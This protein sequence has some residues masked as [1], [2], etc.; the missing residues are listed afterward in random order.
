VHSH[1]HRSCGCKLG[2]NCPTD[3]PTDKY[4]AICWNNLRNKPVRSV[5]FKS[6]DSS[7]TPP[8]HVLPCLLNRQK[9]VRLAVCAGYSPSAAVY[10]GAFSRNVNISVIGSQP[11][12]TLSGPDFHCEQLPPNPEAHASCS[13]PH[14]TPRPPPPPPHLTSEVA[15]GSASSVVIESSTSRDYHGNPVPAEGTEGRS[16]SLDITTADELPACAALP[17]AETDDNNFSISLR[18]SVFSRPAQPTTTTTTAAGNAAAPPALLSY[19]ATATEG[20]GTVFRAIAKG[21]APQP[22]AQP[23]PRTPVTETASWSL[24]VPLPLPS[25]TPLSPATPAGAAAAKE[26][27]FPARNVDSWVQGHQRSSSDVPHPHEPML[28]SPAPSGH[29]ATHATSSLA[30]EDTSSRLM[31]LEQQDPCSQGTSATGSEFEAAWHHA[32]AVLTPSNGPWRE[33]TPGA[34]L[35]EAAAPSSDG[36]S[37]NLHIAIPQP[38]EQQSS[39]GGHERESASAMSKTQAQLALANPSREAV[40]LL[41]CKPVPLSGSHM[42]AGI[43]DTPTRTLVNGV[44]TSAQQYVAAAERSASDALPSLHRT[45]PAPA[46]GVPCKPLSPLRLGSVADSVATGDQHSPTPTE[47]PPPCLSTP[48]WDAAVGA[49]ATGP[50]GTRLKFVGAGLRHRLYDVAL[51]VKSGNASSCFRYTKMLHIKDKFILENKTGSVLQ[52]RSPHCRFS[53]AA[54]QLRGACCSIAANR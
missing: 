35:A 18:A 29:G 31:E 49:W 17:S 25:A 53:C 10:K 38:G 48:G 34:P 54:C 1:I 41:P 39:C 19:E 33:I 37:C 44:A 14:R 11:S 22:R 16:I 2:P 46:V 50:I 52:V 12:L 40:P 42:I 7:A 20:A 47:Q 27:N 6:N 24:L 9:R 8:L 43:D 3:T 51:E 26:P 13:L 30:T 4:A 23:H 32:P 36:S 45:Y 21:T 5:G 28:E 15:S